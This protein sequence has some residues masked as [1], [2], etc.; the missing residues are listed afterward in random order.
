MNAANILATDAWTREDEATC[1]RRPASRVPGWG[2]WNEAMCE[3]RGAGSLPLML[4]RSPW[5]AG[6]AVGGVDRANATLVVYRA[7][8]HERSGLTR[9]RLAV[10]RPSGMSWLCYGLR[11][12]DTSIPKPGFVSPSSRKSSLD[13]V[14]PRSS[15]SGSR[16][17]RGWDADIPRL[18]IATPP[19][20]PRG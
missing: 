19:L 18:R 13:G 1:T 15:W 14:D 5:Y 8:A 17:R 16:R 10:D 2:E 9:C 12:D 3:L 6:A 11:D 4:S 7:R 20:V